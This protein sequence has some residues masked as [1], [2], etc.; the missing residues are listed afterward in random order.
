MNVPS[1]M[2]AKAGCGAG[3]DCGRRTPLRR[4]VQEFLIR[5]FD[6]MGDWQD[7]AAARRRLMTLDER[8]LHD[9]GLNRDAIDA[10]AHKPFWR[11]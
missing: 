6:A 7:R 5:V 10:E 9:L 8:A 2:V 11:P 4:K 1:S 3:I